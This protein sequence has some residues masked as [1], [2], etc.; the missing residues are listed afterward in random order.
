MWPEGYRLAAV[1]H[2]RYPECTKIPL[3]SVVSR[4]GEHA[5][6]ILEDF[7]HY[8]PEKRPNAQQSLRYPY[9]QSMIRP[10][11]QNNKRLTNYVNPQQ[12]LPQNNIQQIRILNPV[13]VP[14]KPLQN[15]RSSKLSYISTEA[16]KNEINDRQNEETKS[17]FS[18]YN[19]NAIIKD[20]SDLI[21]AR[22]EKMK[23]DLNT[24]SNEYYVNNL[25][26][27]NN[28]N[29]GNLRSFSVYEPK[30]NH[31]SSAKSTNGYYMNGKIPSNSDSKVYNAFSKI[32]NPSAS[33]IL[34]ESFNRNSNLNKEETLSSRNRL[35][36]P[37]IWD[38][39]ETDDLDKI[40]G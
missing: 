13:D 37:K 21:S 9:F 40:L 27:M 36:H 23:Y 25:F 24:K 20:T 8:D 6:D 35:A 39:T 26:G 1:I 29:N 32:S 5:L 22:S 34:N 10:S 30:P 16:L 17:N 11:V 31:N 28:N 3:S 14:N 15:G 18:V 4:A 12:I 19:P 38:S 33:I 2:F 7:L